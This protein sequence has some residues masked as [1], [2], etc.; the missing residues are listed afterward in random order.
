[1]SVVVYDAR[2]V[3]FFFFFFLSVMIWMEFVQ[4]PYDTS[5]VCPHIAFTLLAGR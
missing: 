3:D 5:L 1:M 2:G 4:Q